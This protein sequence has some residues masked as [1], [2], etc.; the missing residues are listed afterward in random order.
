M[1]TKKQKKEL[2]ALSAMPDDAIDFTD[3]PAITDK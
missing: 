1:P 2:E 3:I